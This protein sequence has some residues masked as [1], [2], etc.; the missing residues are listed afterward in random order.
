MVNDEEAEFYMSGNESYLRETFIDNGWPLM[1][2]A[3]VEGEQ[4]E[5]IENSDTGDID[6]TEAL[7][8]TEDLDQTGDLDHV[9]DEDVDHP[10]GD[11]D[12]DDE[13]DDED[14]DYEE[15]DEI[16]TETNPNSDEVGEQGKA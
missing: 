6:Q 15:K 5:D 7:D 10:D 2:P 12:D 8:Q 11:D 3:F 1:K 4:I 9:Y 14:E 13:E 16:Q